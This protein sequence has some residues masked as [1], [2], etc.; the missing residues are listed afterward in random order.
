[1]NGKKETSLSNR[2]V[3]R[4]NAEGKRLT[5]KFAN[6]EVGVEEVVQFVKAT[7]E[8]CAKTHTDPFQIKEE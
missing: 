7:A 2:I 6:E 5:V 1:M 8:K 4:S 3:L